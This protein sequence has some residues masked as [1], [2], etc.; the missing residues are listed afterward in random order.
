[1]NKSFILAFNIRQMIA[2]PVKV[3]LNFLITPL[4]VSSKLNLFNLL[5]TARDTNN[6]NNPYVR[7]V[8]VK[9]GV[10]IEKKSFLFL[11]NGSFYQAWVWIFVMREKSPYL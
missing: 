7:G 1:M 6:N 2:L 5:E 9:F 10:I 8:N 4:A 3:L 11:T